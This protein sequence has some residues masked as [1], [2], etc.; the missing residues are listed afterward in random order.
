MEDLSKR[1]NKVAK[2]LQPFIAIGIL[3]MLIFAVIGLNHYRKVYTELKDKGY[4]H[5]GKAVCFCN[6]NLQNYSEN[7]NI[8]NSLI[9]NYNGS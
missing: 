4:F 1:I 3:I 2:K 8:N 7:T 6:N 5:Q 9:I